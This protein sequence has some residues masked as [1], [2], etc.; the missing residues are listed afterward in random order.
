MFQRNAGHAIVTAIMTVLRVSFAVQMANAILIH[1]ALIAE[2]ASTALG[3]LATAV[4]RVKYATSPTAKGQE[5]V[6]LEQKSIFISMS[7]R[8]L[9]LGEPR[10]TTL[11]EAHSSFTLLILVDAPHAQPRTA[12][13]DLTCLVTL[14]QQETG[15]S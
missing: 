6:A 13:V 12:A 10:L 15:W 2:K 9:P 11:L 14:A 3:P 4:Q 1:H 8:L 7:F 5:P